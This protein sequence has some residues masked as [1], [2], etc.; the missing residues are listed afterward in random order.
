LYHQIVLLLRKLMKD[1]GVAFAFHGEYGEWSEN[2]T[3]D[4]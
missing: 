1:A 2:I 4:R 3:V